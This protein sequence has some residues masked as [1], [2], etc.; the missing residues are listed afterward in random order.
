[1]SPRGPGGTPIVVALPGGA[2]PVSTRCSAADDNANVV[3]ATL[4]YGAFA[5]DP[6]YATLPVLVDSAG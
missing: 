6:T 5:M 2:R 1:M 4:M 3:I